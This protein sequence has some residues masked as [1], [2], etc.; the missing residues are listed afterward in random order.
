ML[1]RSTSDPG[2][3][4]LLRVAMIWSARATRHEPTRSRER[5]T[6]RGTNGRSTRASIKTK[7]ATSATDSP[8]GPRAL[9]ERE[10]LHEEEILEVAGLRSQTKQGLKEFDS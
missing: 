5:K 1:G 6:P 7:T 8:K 2:R 10:T 4:E 9:L 3:A